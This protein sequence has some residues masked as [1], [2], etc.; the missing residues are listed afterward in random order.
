MRS[1]DPNAEFSDMA[2]KALSIEFLVENAPTVFSPPSWW[3]L[4]MITN[5]LIRVEYGLSPL[6]YF[7]GLFGVLSFLFHAIVVNLREDIY[8]V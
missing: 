7:F 8:H 3:P 6:P 5:F 1:R 2:G 4:L